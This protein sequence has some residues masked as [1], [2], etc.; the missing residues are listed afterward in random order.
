MDVVRHHDVCVKVVMVKRI[1]SVLDPIN[2]YFRDFLLFKPGWT[3]SRLVEI[4]IH[5]D[6][7]LP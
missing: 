4:A 6:K 5:P 3:D 1:G 7:R 2:D